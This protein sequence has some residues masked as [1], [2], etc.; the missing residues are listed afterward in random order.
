MLLNAK[1][2][3]LKA[4]INGQVVTEISDTT[5]T[6]GMA[7]LGTSFHLVDFDNFEVK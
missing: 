5:Y 4:I 2:D 3:K 6:H 1:G 7:G